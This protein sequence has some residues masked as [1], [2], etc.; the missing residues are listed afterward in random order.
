MKTVK[1]SELSNMKMVAG[2]EKKYDAVIVDGVVKEWVGIGWIET[3][4][5]PDPKKYPTAV[6][7]LNTTDNVGKN[8]DTKA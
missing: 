4:A 7:Y 3:D 2:N 5:K 8:I 6:E 1:R